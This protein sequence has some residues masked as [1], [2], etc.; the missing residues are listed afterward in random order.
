MP[1]SGSEA[2]ILWDSAYALMTQNPKLSVRDRSIIKDITPS[3]VFDSMIVLVASND[4]TRV[5]IENQFDEQVQSA[6]SQ[7]A[8]RSMNFVIKIDS[9]KSK[10]EESESSDTADTAGT[11]PA[12][13][14]EPQQE[15][16]P[17]A[18][19]QAMPPHEQQS[20]AHPHATQDVLQGFGTVG[21]DDLLAH[22]D[23]KKDVQQPDSAAGATD[24]SPA[25]KNG[26]QGEIPFHRDEK[27]HLNKDATFDNFVPGESNRFARAAAFAVSEAPGN[28]YNPLFIYGGSGLGKTHLLNAIGNYALNLY[29]DLTVRYVNSEEFT[30]EFIEAVK[31]GAGNDGEIAE[32]NRRYR[33]VDLLLIDDIQFLGGKTGTMETFFHTFNALY[34]ANKQIVVA[35]DVAPKLLQGFEQRL[36]SRF[37]MGLTVDV[38]P[39]NQETRIAI[40][41]MKASTSKLK[42]DVPM[43]VLDLIAQQVT[44][45]IRELE[46][47][48]TRVVAMA[49]L[50]KQPVTT[51]LAEQTL[52][53]YFVSDVQ[54]TPT[55]IISQTSAYFQL[56][57]DD[58]VSSRRSKNIALA[59]QVAMYICREM[60]GLS[61][62]S[63]GEI[64]GG[65]DHTTVIHAYQKISSEMSEK[66]EVY[67]YVNEL[68][69]KLKQR[70]DS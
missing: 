30:N 33:E 55:D 25:K 43:E 66:R 5:A 21:D 68:T 22:T 47:A 39:P 70:M 27:S 12:E 60:T 17:Q 2:Q 41:R 48:L 20:P 19:E 51:A 11:A 45:N 50:N 53:D 57:F 32:F 14:P 69:S 49:S 67:N 28:S 6:L 26:Q 29:P 58:L 61:L 40:L 16:V 54:V 4:F 42:M 38:Q 23:L 7:A 15:Q 24:T 3:M 1:T 36:I 65:R 62:T 64:F 18:T 35:S 63:I 8:G 9:S 59:R 34:N 44:D 31:E 52:Q 56:T 13:E 10:Q 37:E 46:G